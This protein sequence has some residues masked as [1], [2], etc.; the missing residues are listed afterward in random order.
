M[1]RDCLIFGIIPRLR[2]SQKFALVAN[3]F[4]A[5]QI[6]LGVRGGK[7]SFGLNGND[8]V[9]RSDVWGFHK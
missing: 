8:L 9:C 5:V 3:G 6:H 7:E 2:A 4:I 1:S